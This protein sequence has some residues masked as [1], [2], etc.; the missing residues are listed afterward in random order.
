MKRDGDFGNLVRRDTD[1][2]TRGRGEERSVGKYVVYSVKA[3]NYV[4]PWGVDVLRG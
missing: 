2:R 1:Q 4:K 3:L